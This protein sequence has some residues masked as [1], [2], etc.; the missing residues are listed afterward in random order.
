M[1]CRRSIFYRFLIS[2]VAHSPPGAGGSG[3]FRA[4]LS[5][6]PTCPRLCAGGGHGRGT[7]PSRGPSTQEGLR[8][9]AEQRQEGMKD[10]AR[11][12]SVLQESS[13]FSA[14]SD[15]LFLGVR[16]QVF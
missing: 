11:E 9:V 16:F 7:M 1:P 5:V 8:A 4:L 14:P 13:A 6:L 15:K 12:H 2:H 10:R 3:G